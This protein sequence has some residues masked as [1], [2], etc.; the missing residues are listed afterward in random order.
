MSFSARNCLIRN[1][2]AFIC[3]FTN[4][5][6]DPVANHQNNKKTISLRGCDRFMNAKVVLLIF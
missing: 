6:W 3:K 1:H 4:F 2:L 5:A